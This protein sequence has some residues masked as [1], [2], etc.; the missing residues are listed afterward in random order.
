[1]D[2]DVKTK[3]VHD[4]LCFEDINEHVLATISLLDIMS[5]ME[6][7]ADMIETYVV[8]V[9]PD[10]KIDQIDIMADARNNKYTTVKSGTF[11]IDVFYK[12][13]NCYNITQLT[14]T[15]TR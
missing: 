3:N 11:I 8:D 7:V 10:Y 9:A 2:V 4:K 5:D 14:Y 15:I 1:M 6:D 13:I 12:H